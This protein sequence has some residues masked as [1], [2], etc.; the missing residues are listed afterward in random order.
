[1]RIA[2]L[3]DSLEDQFLFK[4]LC[5]ELGYEVT[6]LNTIENLKAY[7]ILFTDLNLMPLGLYGDETISK[8]KSEFNGDII[9]VSGV[10]GGNYEE[11]AKSYQM[12][13]G[14]QFISKA[15]LSKEKVHAILK[16]N[17][18]L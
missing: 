13:Y 16:Q 12:Q 8:L 14:V 7:D 1:M 15:V 3:E 9:V 6:L 5:Q 17:T 2:Y 11:I 10:G 4:G 18:S